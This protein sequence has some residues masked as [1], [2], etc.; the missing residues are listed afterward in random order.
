MVIAARYDAPLH[1]IAGT[2][3]G[4]LIAD[5]PAVIAGDS[6]ADRMPVKWIRLVAAGIFAALGVATL[7]GVG[8][9]FDF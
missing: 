4:M 7:M 1:V 9:G 6:L 2:T 8:S 5:V 3:L